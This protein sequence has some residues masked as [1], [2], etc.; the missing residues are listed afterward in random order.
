MTRRDDA[1]EFLEGHG[2]ED[3]MLDE[4]GDNTGDA[5]DRYWG[6]LLFGTTVAEQSRGQ[7]HEERLAEEEPDTVDGDDEV[8][9]WED[10]R[11]TQ[12]EIA[13]VVSGANGSHSRTDPDLIGPDL[14]E[15]GLSAEEAAL[16]VTDL[17]AEPTTD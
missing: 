3:T 16:H 11:R 4:T 7:S 12:R 6:S 14:G 15:L 8:P 2:A 17:P 9:E 10:T 5:G 13:Q 1:G